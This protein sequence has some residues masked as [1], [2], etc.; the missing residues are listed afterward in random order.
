[1]R[2]RFL[3]LLILVLLGVLVSFGTAFASEDSDAGKT[4]ESDTETKKASLSED[5]NYYVFGRVVDLTESIPQED[6]LELSRYIFR[7]MEDVHCDMQIYIVESVEK[8]GYATMD[9]FTDASYFDEKYPA[10]YGLEGSA[11][12]LVYETAKKEAHVT[13]YGSSSLFYEWPVL[14]ARLFFEYYV[15]VGNAYDGCVGF[16]DRLWKE[17]NP[18]HEAAALRTEMMNAE[19][20]KPYNNPNIARVLDYANIISDSGE[21]KMTEKIEEIRKAYGIDVVVLTAPDADGKDSESFNDDFYDYVGFGVGP[22]RDGIILFVNMDP[23]VRY[24]T[25][26][27]CG[28]GQDYFNDA[29]EDIYDKMLG[30]FK[31]KDY[32]AGIWVYVDE[33]VRNI[34]HSRTI[35]EFNGI[36]YEDIKE[37]DEDEPRVIDP[38]EVLSESKRKSLEKQIAEIS[39]KYH[40]DVLVMIQN[41]PE[42]YFAEDYLGLYYKYMGYGAGRKNSGIAV[43]ID[44]DD[45][46]NLKI[47]AFGESEKLFDGSARNR[48]FSMVK[49]SLGSKGNVS[50]AADTFVK[51]VRFRARW[52]HYPMTTGMTIFMIV[53]IYIVVS[54]IASAKKAKNNTVATAVSASEY[55]APGSS[56]VFN[57][58]ERFL[59]SKVTKTRK[60]EPSSS[61]RSGGGGGGSHYSSSGTSHGGGGGRHF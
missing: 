49:S 13:F 17:L 29:V 46:N 9:E 20:F 22:D 35:D 19:Y 45:T 32:E 27:T 10:G 8:C 14:K 43:F 41:E 51:K 38:G 36:R 7:F 56:K 50:R 48:L 23:N 53:V 59:N 60:P 52:K 4:S 58:R 47:R 33:V 30:S 39:K 61:S 54:I 44:P 28:L 31:E 21:A 40:M 12:I 55:L 18:G 42:E 5:G 2:R 34:N 16:I 25:I 11:V 15:R 37:A 57:V 3:S 24:Y 26:S 6:R 1:M